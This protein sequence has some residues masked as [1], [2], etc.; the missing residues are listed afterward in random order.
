M[1]TK[2]TLLGLLFFWLNL[3][4]SAQ[5]ILLKGRVSDAATS[6]G[7][8][9]INV[10]IKNS[11]TG[12]STDTQGLFALRSKVQLPFT[13]QVSGI[14]YKSQEYVVQ[15]TDQ[16][17]D[18]QLVEAPLL[19]NEVVV[20][21]SRVEESI[22]QSPVSVEKIGLKDLKESTAPTFFDAL[23]NLKGVQ[24]T[25]ASLAFR[26]V[27]TRGFNSTTNARF[28][29]LVD[30]VDNQTPGLQFPIGNVAGVS[31]LDIESLELVPGAASALYGM[32]AL[33]GMLNLTTKSPF[34][35][36]GL[37]VYQRTGVTHAD[38]RD[39]SAA[40]LSETALRY[41]KQVGRRF[42]FKVNASYLH[43]TDWVANNYTDIT[44]TLNES[45]GLL[46]A[47]NPARDLVNRYGDET[48]RNLTLGGRTY[49]VGRTGYLDSD[50]TDYRVRNAKF[51]AALH[52]KLSERTTLAYS[53]RIGQADMI[54][55]R[56]NRFQLDD[57]TI[58]Q[59]AAELKGDRFSV[60]AY[61]STENTGNS[62]N[63]RVLGENLEKSNKGNDQWFNDFRTGFNQSTARGSNPT[64]ALTEARAFADA[65]RRQS[66][67]SDLANEINRLANINDWNVG[68]QFVSQARLYHAEGQYQIG[69]IGRLFH[70]Q[71]GFDS[72]LY[73]VVPDGNNFRDRLETGSDI[74]MYKVGGFVQATRQFWNGKLK[75]E[76]SLRVDKNEYFEAKLNPR[77]A[78]VFSP[79]EQHYIRT[80]L[81][82]GYRFPTL[83]ESFAF[84]N[85]GGV[86]RTGGLPGNSQDLRIYENSFLRS[87]VVEFNAAVNRSRNTQGLSEE[88]AIAQ[89][90]NLL[91]KAEVAYIKPE[92][93]TAF[94]IGYKGLWLGGKL[95]V[96]A[97][98]YRYRSFDFIGNVDLDQPA[99][100]EISENLLQAA[101]NIRPGTSGATM[102]RYRV[103]TNSQ[104]DV[105]NQGF[106]A[107]VKYNFYKTYQLSGNYTFAVL[108]KRNSA[109]PLIPG[110]NTPRNAFNLSLSNSKVT[111]RLGFNVN[112]RWVESFLWQSPFVDGQIPTYHTV[113]AQ[114]SYKIPSLKTSVKLGGTNIFNQRFVQ[115]YGGPTMGALYYATIVFDQLFY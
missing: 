2:I 66:G 61:F 76:A 93:V 105:I 7:L 83:W 62:T 38:G 104:S 108:E 110:F 96:D 92:G 60:R 74:T 63:M 23:E 112:F 31:E 50:L 51:D 45:V 30:G 9:G 27:N 91:R 17:I 113:D 34:L 106:S 25:T 49:V 57:Y 89:H 6:E 16:L 55:Q 54:F 29:Q 5:E 39:R 71:A 58:Q 65:G 19:G 107:Q 3:E 42:A 46:G 52:Y 114:V 69:Q 99:G 72:R 22:L 75:L 44:P 1:K 73:R 12:A 48:R 94:E 18:I 95:Y 100:V 43:A 14:G 80:S 78:A 56:G 68:A 33:N 10:L 35:Y 101:R 109:D 88:Q 47:E 4:A 87:S 32:N 81:Q 15:S 59:H 90:V 70:L 21:A 8:G 13:L 79:K 64:Q 111:P 115:A 37:S 86:I 82:N 36:Q 53:Y 24:M 103:H 85:N 20:T 28:L 77:V 67:S 41:A 40:P 102:Q 84:L 97:E 26:T 98:Y 11:T